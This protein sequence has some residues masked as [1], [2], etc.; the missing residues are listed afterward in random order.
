MFGT[1]PTIA[2]FKLCDVDPTVHAPY[3]CHPHHDEQNPLA[4]TRQRRHS[5]NRENNNNNNNNNSNNDE[6]EDGGD[7]NENGLVF[8]N[9]CTHSRT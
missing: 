8:T 4:A 5:N 2:Y 7:D 6:D 9:A 3:E 1:S